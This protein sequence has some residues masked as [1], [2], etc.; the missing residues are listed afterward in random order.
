MN[1]QMLLTRCLR[2]L[3]CAAIWLMFVA[4]AA[5]EWGTVQSFP[6]PRTRMRNSLTVEVDTRGVVANGYRTV[7]VKVFNTPN[8]NKPPVPVTADRRVRVLLEP[9]GAGHLSSVATSQVIEI[10][11]K[12]ASGEATI[13]IPAAGD[14][15]QIDVTVYE[16]GDK[17]DDVSGQIRIGFFGMRSD[18]ESLPTLLFIDDDVPDRATRDRQL[19][20]ITVAAGGATDTYNLPDFSNVLV[21]L[22]YSNVG[23][24]PTAIPV[25][26]ASG[27]PNRLTDFQVLALTTQQSKVQLLPP[28][29]LPR[30]WIELSCYDI[31]FISLDDLAKMSRQH[32]R[33]RRALA[34]WLQT[35]P[36]LVVYGVG[37]DLA[38]LKE[39]E[40]LLELPPLSDHSKQAPQLRGWTP[41]NWNEMK[42]PYP[43]QSQQVVYGPTGMSSMAMATK[44]AGT[45]IATPSKPLF[46]PQGGSF[47]GRPA[48]LGWVI[49]V[50]HA[51]PFPA[52][53]RDWQWI[54]SS[55]STRHQLWSTR[56]GI[57]YQSYN[58]GLWNWYIQGVGAAPVFSF[59][60]LATL[61][62]IV[63]GPVNYLLLGKI[64]RLYL[65]LVTV[66]IG[67]AVV[68]LSLFA[69]AVLSDGLGVKAR[70]RSFSL[71]DQQTGRS[72]SWSR[73]SYYASLVPSQGLKFPDDAVVWPLD[74]RPIPHRPGPSRQ[75]IWEADGQ[76]LKSG[77]L[78]SRRLTQLMV[79]RATKTKARLAV[80]QPRPGE[81]PQ[82]TNG[83]EGTIERLFLC[84]AQG[85]FFEAEEPLAADKSQALKPIKAEEFH[86]SINQIIGEHRPE[87]P[88][89]YDPVAE[90]RRTY[91]SWNRYYWGRTSNSAVLETSI[92]ETNLA[93]LRDYLTPGTYLAVTKTN[94]GV[95]LGIEKVTEAQS[96][97]VIV[98]RW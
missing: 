31:A 74:E 38:R 76:R 63:I 41:A 57:S 1:D 68:T 88:E 3:G 25:P 33:Q 90:E 93:A 14:W 43:S 65:L 46:D 9:Y 7:L 87:F 23:M 20:T 78:S 94:P 64:Q 60:L 79:I 21:N 85:K 8:R 52:S 29:E 30:R 70:I 51:D 96:F 26:S 10:P 67:A 18:T 36:A 62:A 97:H 2:I 15:N 19:S 91:S 17:L 39:V 92:L 72:V 73:Q 61:F 11:E 77:Y 27:N 89:G 75:L 40:Q 32:S 55:I 66:P 45:S 5:A 22:P 48:G 53:E 98:G 35:G 24:A 80:A 95:P 82:V 42:L 81:P 49:A 59:L 86:L 28:D 16:G 47:A 44:A 37:K 12:Q 58:Q 56:H 34:D 83:L 4:V 71:L 6:L 84:D 54:L 69:Y 50:D 13:A